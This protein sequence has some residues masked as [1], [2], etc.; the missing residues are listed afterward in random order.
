MCSAYAAAAASIQ[1]AEASFDEVGKQS[2][3]EF[4]APDRSTVVA[5]VLALAAD[6]T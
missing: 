1:S 3:F 6:E 4:A 5:D 2:T